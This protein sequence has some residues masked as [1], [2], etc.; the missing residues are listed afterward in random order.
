MRQPH[1]LSTP[2]RVRL[3]GVQ[4]QADCGREVPSATCMAMADTYEPVWLSG[5]KLCKSCQKVHKSGRYLYVIREGNPDI[6]ET[7]SD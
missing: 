2:E 1:L 6:D 5:A 3:W 7:Y 4:L